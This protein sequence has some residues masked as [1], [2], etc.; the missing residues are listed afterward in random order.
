MVFEEVCEAL[1]YE[2]PLD[3]A[4]ESSREVIVKTA[5]RFSDNGAKPIHP[6]DA[7]RIRAE[8]DMFA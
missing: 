5:E 1:G 4:D 3:W 7:H 8:I 2:E 6:A